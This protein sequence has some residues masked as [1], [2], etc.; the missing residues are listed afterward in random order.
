MIIP[1]YVRKKNN[2]HMVKYYRIIEFYIYRILYICNNYKY[3][4]IHL[5]GKK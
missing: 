3:K 2:Y 5:F 4:I 1:K